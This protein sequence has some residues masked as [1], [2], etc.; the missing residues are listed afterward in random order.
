MSNGL[1]FNTYAARYMAKV[2]EVGGTTPGLL[3]QQAFEQLAVD[4]FIG[5]RGRGAVWPIYGGTEA[6]HEL[7][8]FRG[9]DIDS[10]PNGALTHSA[11]GMIGDGVSELGVVS[12]LKPATFLGDVKFSMGVYSRSALNNDG[13]YDIGYN[14]IKLNCRNAA[15][16][17]LSYSGTLSSLATG[18]VT[19][20]Q[21]LFW[22]NRTSSTSAQGYRNATQETNNT[23]TTVSVLPN[24]NI[25]I[26]G[27]TAS[28]TSARQI[29]FAFFGPNV[30][31]G[32]NLFYPLVQDYQ[33]ALNRQV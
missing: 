7:D 22:M 16:N 23:T 25:G 29:A 12:T 1:G 33:T 17:M 9:H 30:A 31:V 26:G 13:Y 19:N 14:Q 8:L 24:V 20:S 10:W 3:V 6:S 5:L 15:G 27:S 21:G 4:M 18:P 2:V 11:N 32:A 28:T